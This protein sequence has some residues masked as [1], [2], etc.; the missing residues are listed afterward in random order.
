[1]GNTVIDIALFCA[2]W[3]EKI[4]DEVL[5]YVRHSSDYHRHKYTNIY[6]VK[7][8]QN[9]FKHTQI[10]T[11]NGINACSSHIIYIKHH[12]PRP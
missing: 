11:H 10:Q 5:Y 3:D 1:M 8:T 9:M 12:D 2:W 7:H 4:H 6:T